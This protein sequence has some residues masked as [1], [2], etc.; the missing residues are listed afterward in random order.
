MYMKLSDPQSGGIQ[1]NLFNLSSERNR[2][3]PCRDSDDFKNSDG[4][5]SKHI[6]WQV[7]KWDF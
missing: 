5:K 6:Q 4:D 2:E 1:N 7:Y 3:L